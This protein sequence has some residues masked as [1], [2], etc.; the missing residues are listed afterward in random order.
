[1]IFST[2]I[3]STADF[4]SITIWYI[5][6]QSFSCVF[7]ITFLDFENKAAIAI[8]RIQEQEQWEKRVFV[9]FTQVYDVVRS[10]HWKH[11]YLLI[12]NSSGWKNTKITNSQNEAPEKKCVLKMLLPC[13]IWIKVNLSFVYGNIIVFICFFRLPASDTGSV[14]IIINSK[15]NFE[16]VT[17]KTKF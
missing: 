2:K 11:Q 7:Y 10:F 17:L 12:K 1:M 4:C 5:G 6:V 15:L 3:Y 14:S 9:H 13:F 16:F 8:Q